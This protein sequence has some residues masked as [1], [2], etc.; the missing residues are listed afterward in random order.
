MPK[1]RCLPGVSTA[2][3]TDNLVH[4][5]EFFP[6]FQAK[7]KD[8]DRSGSVVSKFRSDLVK[9]HKLSRVTGGIAGGADW[10]RS[11]QHSISQ[12]QTDSI[13]NPNN[14]CGSLHKMC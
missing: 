11:I 2:G 4:S 9:I 10:R 3:R 12:E 8:S 6:V 5:T 1:I 14:M 7:S 13:T